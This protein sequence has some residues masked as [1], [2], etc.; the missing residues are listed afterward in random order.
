V[1]DEAK[2]SEASVSYVKSYLPEA[3]E[4]EERVSITGEP[5]FLTEIKKLEEQVREIREER[6]E[7]FQEL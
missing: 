2:L 7:L 3:F 1:I 5:K 4:E 6:L